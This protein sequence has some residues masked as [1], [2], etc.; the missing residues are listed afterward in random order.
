MLEVDAAVSALRSRAVTLLKDLV[1]ADSTVGHEVAAQEVLAV[2]LADAG[3]T[4]ERLDIPESIA[5][6]PLAG[7]PLVSYAGR[8]VLV[9]RRPAAPGPS[10]APSLLV[11]GHMDVVPVEEAGGWTTSPFEPH[12]RDGWLFG[13]GAG[14]M[15]CG[16][17]MGWLA[18]RAL[19]AARPGW[20]RGDLTI[21]SV[22]EEECTGNG[23]LAACRAGVVADAALLLE[24]TDLELLLAG[25]AIV[26]VEISVQG[27][28]AHAEAAGRSVNPILASA[29]VLQGLL[30]LEARMN[31]EHVAGDGDPAFVGM[32]KPY[33]VNVGRF[34]SGSWASSVPGVAR[35]EVRVGHPACWSAEMTL[36]RVREA[37]LGAAAGDVWL[38]EH[39]PTFRLSG[40]R[41]QRY[42]QEA[43]DSFVRRLAAAHA[44]VHGR[45]PAAVAI[46][47]T[48]DARYY[49]NL[50]GIPTVAYG[51]R[52]RNLHGVDEAVELASIVEGARTL[53]RFFA[54]WLG[55]EECAGG[56]EFADVG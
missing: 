31:E 34:N 26:W 8:F 21:V 37:V 25:V 3:F 45:E 35:L 14:D 27:R 7:V 54:D 55:R 49:R 39:P 4:V 28:A 46:G 41:A 9:A 32:R 29:P 47:S 24:P 53:T 5:Q 13:R 43:D 38:T 36:E 17:A 18:I 15:K 48:T 6:D 19:D 1:R 20:Q 16:F 40:F 50:V 44:A 56:E 33:L 10:S 2:A 23:T 51:P 22:I 11:N 52:T 30:G 42:A 12:E